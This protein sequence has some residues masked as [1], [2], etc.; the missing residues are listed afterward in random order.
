[1]LQSIHAPK[2]V[3]EGT[4][5]Y[6][7]EILAVPIWKTPPKAPATPSPPAAR[8]RGVNLDLPGVRATERK[9]LTWVLGP[10]LRS[11]SPDGELRSAGWGAKNRGGRRARQKTGGGK[12]DLVPSVGAR[13]HRGRLAG[14]ICQDFSNMSIMSVQ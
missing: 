8:E 5:S 4:R 12:S 9:I 10:F 3:V 14:K 1:M 13:S 2:S 11:L 6:N 7:H